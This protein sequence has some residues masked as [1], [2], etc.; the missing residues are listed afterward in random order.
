M[1]GPVCLCV[2][3][4][5]QTDNTPVHSHSTF[6]V[7]S[8]G[9][10]GGELEVSVHPDTASLELLSHALRTRNIL[11]PDGAT[12]AQL[13]VV[14]AADDLILA[15]PLEHG[16]NGAERLVGHDG[17]IVGG[18][19]NDGRGH[20]EAL[21]RLGAGLAAEGRLPPLLAD[22]RVEGLQLV[23]LHLVLDGAEEGLG[24]LVVTLLE[25]LDQGDQRR[26]E[27]VVDILVHVDALDVHADLSAVH[28]AEEADLG[29]DGVNIDVVT[30]DGCVVAAQLERHA[31]QGSSACCHNSLARLDRAGEGDLGDVRVSSEL[32]SQRLVA[33]KG[34]EDSRRKDLGADLS[35][36]EGCVRREWRRLPD[37]C[38]SGH[39]G[40]SQ[41]SDSQCKGE[42][43]RHDTDT[44][45]EG[46]VSYNGSPL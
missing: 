11:R 15:G 4:A 12:Q 33:A 46:D 27:L 16:D 39:E 43:P 40:G 13:R 18:V 36:L 9:H 29:H 26:Q 44:Y 24:V 45:T 19:I 3:P 7:S 10:V 38:V 17:R 34:L 23:V 6:L 14:G 32:G 22:L 41:L 20:V 35:D 31:L 37:V 2:C 1:L 25:G 5:L 8:K 30:Y 21:A 42:V 28:E